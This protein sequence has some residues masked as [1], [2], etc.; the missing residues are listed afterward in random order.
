[1][2]DYSL[3]PR[4]ASTNRW[5]ASDLDAAMRCTKGSYLP[6]ITATGGTPAVGTGFLTGKWNRNGLRVWGSFDLLISGG[7]IAGTSWRISLPFL[8][9]LT[10]HTAGVLAAASD[11][12]GCG[13][14]SSG[15]SSQAVVFT[16]LLSAAAEMVFYFNASTTSLGS[17]NFTTTARMKGKFRYLA[18]PADPGIV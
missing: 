17:A 12:I 2:P 14:T 10:H 11:C 15:T 6:S 18:N 1:V 4:Y 9:D 5:D 16:T 3:F 7:T 13:Q 8:A